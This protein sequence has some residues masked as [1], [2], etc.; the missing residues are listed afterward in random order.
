MVATPIERPR[1]VNT[2][3]TLGARRFLKQLREE[4]RRHPGVNHIFLNRLATM[5]FTREDYLVFGLQHYPLINCFTHYME[6]L[7]VRAPNSDSKLWLAKVLVDEYGEGSDGD[8][9][10]TL[11]LKFLR[12]AGVREAQLSRT[13]LNPYTIDFV[14]THVHLTTRRPFLEGLGAIGPGH[15]WAIPSMFESIVP[16]LR[17]AGFA[18]DEI[19]Y[20]WLHQDQDEDH[21]AWLEEALVDLAVTTEARDQIRRGALASLDARERFWT[22]AQREVVRWRQPLSAKNALRKV[23]RGAHTLLSEAEDRSRLSLGKRGIARLRRRLTP[24][25]L[26]DVLPRPELAP[27]KP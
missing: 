2:D 16:G 8:D 26:D 5:P 17:R 22:G 4:I 9:H 20:F 13:H 11:Y 1:A 7:L 12:A 27:H 24:I 19:L 18:E 23:Q 10:S 25:Y 15:E 3:T 14:R 6:N 21:G